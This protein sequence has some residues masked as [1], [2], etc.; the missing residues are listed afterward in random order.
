MKKCP[1]CSKEFDDSM[2]FCAACGEKLEEAVDTNSADTQPQQT[3]PAQNT[4]AQNTPVQNTPLTQSYTEPNQKNSNKKYIIALIIAAS[5]IVI[6]LFSM[7]SAS[8][9][10]PP[11]TAGKVT[12]KPIAA[13]VKPATAKPSVPTQKPLPAPTPEPAPVVKEF[14]KENYGYVDYKELARNPDPYKGKSLSFSGKVIQ[15]IEEDDETHHRIAVNGDYDSVIYVAYPKDIVASRILEDDYVTVYGTSLGLYS[16]QSTMGGKITIPAI[17]L[18]R[19]E[20]QQ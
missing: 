14:V 10:T 16:Y 5:I 18:D 4:P 1:K 17:Y 6:L 13:T 3:T 15:V 19:I 9:K 8:D 11:K 2:N 20:L 7:C 12:E